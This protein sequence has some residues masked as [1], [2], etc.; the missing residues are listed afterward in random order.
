[1]SD[2]IDLILLD[3]CRA[4][5][6]TL[7]ERIRI[8]RWAAADPARA[9]LLA[10]MQSLESAAAELPDP[11]NT[12][13]MLAGMR[14]RLANE[15]K[16]ASPAP[17]R[18]TAFATQRRA[19][20]SDWALRAAAVIGLVAGGMALLRSGSGNA[21]TGSAV[22][23]ASYRTITAGVGERAVIS[24]VDGTRVTVD[25]GST[26][27]I[28]QDFGR[29][30]R[31]VRLDGRAYF[32]V[33]SDSAKP[34]RV[35]SGPGVTRVLGTKF[36]VRAYPEDSAV[37]VV[38]REGRVALATAGDTGAQRGSV[39]LDRGDLGTVDTHGHL[40]V[41]RGVPVD[42]HLA[43]EGGRLQFV[44]TPLRAVLPELTR[45]YGLQIVSFDHQID[46]LLWT[47]SL[48]SESASEALQLLATSLA[49]DVDRRGDRVVLRLHSSKGLSR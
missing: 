43:W 10:W 5:E 27:R 15:A 18:W 4:G 45:R 24:L 22:E 30:A 13:D 25:A 34:F 9:E 42:Q 41:E 2:E 19:S 44:N 32:E 11:W 21:G 28:P 39:V 17:L 36:S 35:Y 33:S 37:T 46:T 3:R 31:D 20:W 23:T 38:V 48:Q 47:A 7:A 6:C 8:E 49:L 16:P 12:Q 14:A 40:R 26:L 29:A 1:M